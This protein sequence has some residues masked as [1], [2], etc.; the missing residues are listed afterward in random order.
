MTEK[1]NIINKYN[2][3]LSSV[4]AQEIRYQLGYTHNSWFREAEEKKTT[5]QSIAGLTYHNYSLK[6]G[7]QQRIQRH[8]LARNPEM[9]KS[10]KTNAEAQPCFEQTQFIGSNTFLALYC[11]CGL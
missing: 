4:S 10:C 8:S 1:I 7:N 11:L 5:V 9:S 6:L 3:I 2:K